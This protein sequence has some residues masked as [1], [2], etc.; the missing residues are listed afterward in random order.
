MAA[1]EEELSSS[2]QAVEVCE[3]RVK[4]IPKGARDFLLAERH[5]TIGGLVPTRKMGLVAEDQEVRSRLCH[6]E[7]W[8]LVRRGLTSQ[9]VTAG[10][11]QDGVPR[12][13]KRVDTDHTDV[14]TFVR[15]RAQALWPLHV[16]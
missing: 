2:R 6:Q 4:S 5:N 7:Q 15:R 8:T 16:H 9:V 12:H 1:T 13:T 11:A 10:H 3:L 14:C